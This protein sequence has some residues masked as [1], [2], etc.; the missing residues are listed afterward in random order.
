MCTQ[1]VACRGR[2]SP[3][4]RAER[5][6]RARLD[7]KD[8]VRQTTPAA[9][10]WLYRSALVLAAC[11]VLHALLVNVALLGGVL[12]WSITKYS[13]VV[14]LSTG[15]SFCFVPGVVHLRNL[16]LEVIDSNVHLEIEV[17][18]GRANITLVNLL[19]KKF[20]TTAVRGEGFVV[21]IRPKF[22]QLPEARR[23]ALP[24]L[25]DPP[26]SGGPPPDPRELWHIDLQGVDAAFDELWVSELRYRGP[27]PAN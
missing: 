8:S 23:A 9:L 1:D 17:R 27:R 2:L 19:S 3:C 16:H 25:A 20:S 21:R 12:G 26:E 22:S 5:L 10:R 24:P 11:F 14:R 18:T 7:K 4:S 13:G 6:A 15:S